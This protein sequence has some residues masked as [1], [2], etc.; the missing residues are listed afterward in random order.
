M[1]TRKMNT[2]QIHYQMLD[3]YKVEPTLILPLNLSEKS[4]I[5]LHLKNKY[6]AT[7]FKLTS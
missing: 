1:I 2:F 6:Y 3:K 7:F 4:I 5:L